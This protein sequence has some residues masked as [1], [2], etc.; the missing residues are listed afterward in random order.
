MVAFWRSQLM[1]A[2]SLTSAKRV[3]TLITTEQFCQTPTARSRDEARGRAIPAV[4]LVPGS[5]F[6]RL[7]SGTASLCVSDWRQTVVGASA[8]WGGTLTGY[9]SF[10][11]MRCRVQLRV[12]RRQG[13]RLRLPRFAALTKSLTMSQHWVRSVGSSATTAMR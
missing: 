10:I 8:E 2:A 12:L 5:L 4:T 7:P 1:G 3:V 9:T 6:L 11:I 13:L